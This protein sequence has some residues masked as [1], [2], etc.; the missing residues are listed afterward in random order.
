MLR[1]VARSPEPRSKRRDERK[2]AGMKT[3]KP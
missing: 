3:K 2:M 1:A